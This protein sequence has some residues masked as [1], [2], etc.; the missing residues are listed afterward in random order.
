MVFP[1]VIS[2]KIKVFFMKL[3]VSRINGEL[4]MHSFVTEWVTH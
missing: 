2:N 4:V 3:L 1:K